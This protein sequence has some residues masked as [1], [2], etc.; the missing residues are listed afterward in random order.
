MPPMG[1]NT[2][3]T[4]QPKCRRTD[5]GSSATF[6]LSIH[7]ANALEQDVV[8]KRELTARSTAFK[9]IMQVVPISME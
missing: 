1:R 9:A 3:T 2:E 8:R 6:P 4:N 7:P 5:N